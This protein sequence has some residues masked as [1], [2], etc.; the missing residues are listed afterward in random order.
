VA[1]AAFL[2][3]L[4]LNFM[5]V[6]Q[7][8]FESII[9]ARAIGKINHYIGIPVF[10]YSG[11]IWKGASEIVVQY[12]YTTTKNF[13][14]RSL[15]VKPT[16]VNY[17]PCIRYRVG[18]VVYRY[19]LWGD[20]GELMPTVPLYNGEVIKKNCVIE[21]WNIESSLIVSNAAELQITTSI[22]SIPED[23]SAV[24]NKEDTDASAAVQPLS[25]VN[26][27]PASPAITGLQFRYRLDDAT[28]SG[29]AI[30]TIPDLSGNSRTMTTVVNAP[31]VATSGGVTEANRTYASISATNRAV[32]FDGSDNITCKHVFFVFR[33]TTH[34]AN[35]IIAKG[36][37][38]DFRQVGGGTALIQARV[39]AVDTELEAPTG[40]TYIVEAYTD[41]DGA[42]YYTKFNLYD[43]YG[44]LLT[45][46]TSGATVTPGA[47]T[48]V[49]IG[50]SAGANSVLMNFLE[51]FGYSD[52]LSTTDVETTID[53][54]VGRYNN[55][56]ILLPNAWTEGSAWL[57]NP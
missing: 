31:T 24:A 3:F 23:Y 18:G 33:P 20:I 17:V 57:D 44:N 37:G 50:D 2:L 32:G 4:L 29:A 14:L 26:A 5:P 35:K 54:I 7:L 8:N 9:P 16:G 25:L 55:N 46:A 49:Y 43:I 28:L 41:Y 15:P 39:G 53:Y 30:V 56:A 42:D 52:E 1:E 10:T 38:I 48:D 22:R 36:G 51:Y 47:D 21:I 12:N 45:T 27:M 11:I 19:K 6:N 34:S 40:V 13:I